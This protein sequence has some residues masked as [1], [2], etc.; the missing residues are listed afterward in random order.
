[1]RR[2]RVLV[3]DDHDLMRNRV[4]H[5]LK[6]EFDVVDAVAD[7]K[8]LLEAAARLKPDV[9]ILDISM[10]ML[11]GIET[12]TQLKQSGSSAKVIFLTIHDDS[13]FVGS[14]FRTGAQGY[15]FKTRMT[16][17]LAFAVREVLA[18]RTFLSSF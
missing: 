2:A 4:V 18:G 3:A 5:L 7:G 14:A 15:V 6:R 12:A 8:A 9:C 10:P 17:D 11:S 16:A 13:D 1:V